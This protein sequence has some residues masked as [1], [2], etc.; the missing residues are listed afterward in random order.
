MAAQTA[1]LESA[2]PQL[3][4][5]GT[6]PRLLY[7]DNLRMVPITA[8]VLG[9]L[10]VT[11]GI[12][13]DWVYYEGGQMSPVLSVVAL[14]AAAIGIGFAMGL[15]F[16]IAG[17]FTPPAYD[18]KGARGFLV[19]RLKRLGIPWLIYE[20]IINPLIH[21]AVDVHGGE[22]QGGLYDCQFQGTFWQYLKDFPRASGSF[23]YGPVW[24]LEALLI[25]SI[26]YALWRMLAAPVT[27]AAAV[28][29]GRTRVV[30]GSG[31]IVLFALVI[32]LS[33]FVVRFW[34]KAFVKYEPFHLE[35]GRFPQYI[36]LFVAGLWACRHDW[37]VAFS[38]RQ[39]KTWR[40]VALACV[41]TLPPLAVAAGVLSGTLDERATGGLNWLSLAYS[42]WEG[43]LCVS[44]II[45]ILAWFRRRLDHQGRLA[46]AMS[47][48]AFAVYVLH[49]AIIV[50]LALALSGIQMNLSL[51]FLL[52][53]PIA[54]TLCY[55]VAY[56]L[57]KVSL[58][59]TILG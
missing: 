8:V 31:A 22:C 40:W 51:K 37:L 12:D 20:V 45:S 42:L 2:K 21:Y 3:S 18:R 41:L 7:L 58:V 6:R 19:N 49:P 50:P 15:F 30:P 57:R 32:G 59:R 35:F 11:Y 47:E 10:S 17:Y 48:S 24:F 56:A 54:V 52:M 34:F 5:S 28:E 36:A 1:T 9:H 13:T 33:T 25:F 53:A 46:R 39:A 44:M 14:L 38:D 26:F 29:P 43:F 27:P 23:G 4:L 16:M 55:L